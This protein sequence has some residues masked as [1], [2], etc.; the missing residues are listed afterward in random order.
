MNNDNL[1][2]DSGNVAVIPVLE[3]GQKITPRRE[4]WQRVART[5]LQLVAAGGLTVLTDQIAS[6]LQPQY[7][8]YFLA[9][10]TLGLTW[11]QN[12]IE[13]QWPQVTILKK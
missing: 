1:I 9:V 4:V 8:A 3:S 13:E 5:G 12:F 10:Y 11:L 7:A 2:D 6:D